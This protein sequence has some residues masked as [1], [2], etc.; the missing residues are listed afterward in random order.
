V[1]DRLL[2]NDEWLHVNEEVA[3]KKMLRC[4]NKDLWRAVVNAV[5]NIRVA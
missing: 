3:C 4:I 5:M 1:S 2:M